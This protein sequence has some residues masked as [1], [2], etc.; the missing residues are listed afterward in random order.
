MI[1]ARL[2]RTLAVGLAAALLALGAQGAVSAEGASADLSVT[3]STSSGS[4]PGGS[5]VAYDMTVANAGPDDATGVTV[6]DT[7][8]AD[9]TLVSASASQGTCDTSTPAT[10]IL[11]SLAAGASATATFTVDTPCAAETL[12]NGAEVVGDQPDPAPSNN[13]SSLT[14]SLTTPCL[15]ADQFVDDGGFVTTDPLGQG[16]QPDA[17][18]FDTSSITVPAG[19]SG[20][21]SI[22]LLTTNPPPPPGICPLFSRLI[23]GTVEPAASEG[24]WLTFVFTYDVC[25]IPPGT[26][27]KRTTMR[28]STDG[29][30]YTPIPRCR[31]MYDNPD[32]C[33]ASKV[34]LGDGS[35]QYTVRWSGTGD[36]SWRPG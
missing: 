13:E 7:I 10:C 11:G 5:F 31:G 8:A 29:L 12:M 28:M 1:K 22:S 36:P 17:G 35:F 34:V 27:I 14:V 15:G 6:V 21:V 20:D 4:F 26:K 3:Q 9:A 16:P 2:P 19:T 24:T 25:S 23:V 32:P 18:V 33:V 30:T